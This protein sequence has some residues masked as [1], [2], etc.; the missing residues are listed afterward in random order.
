VFVPSDF[1]ENLSEGMMAMLDVVCLLTPFM[2]CMG[3]GLGGGADE[4]R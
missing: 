3:P 4:K 2:P 1:W